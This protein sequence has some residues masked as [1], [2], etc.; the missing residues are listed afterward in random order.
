MVL[1]ASSHG[2]QDGSLRT[3]QSGVSIMLL[4]RT[5]TSFTVNSTVSETINAEDNQLETKMVWSD[6]T[7][8]E[9]RDNVT[10]IINITGIER[11][12]SSVQA[13]RI[14]QISDV[15]KDKQF[16]SNALYRKSQTMYYYS[17][18]YNFS[19]CK[20]PKVGSTFWTQVFKILKNGK[21]G[22]NVFKQERKHVHQQS[23]QLVVRFKSKRR[24][25]SKTVLVSRDP[26]S[27]LY[28]AFIDK[29]FLFMHKSTN[30]DIRKRFP[31][32][33]ASD[34]VC[35]TDVSFQEFLDF[36]ISNVKMGNL[37]N[38]H[39]A[40]ISSLCRPCDVN[41]HILVKQESFSADV[42]YALR[43]FG[44]DGE[45]L[46]MIIPALHNNRI[47]DSVIS[48][49]ETFYDKV[50][51]ACIDTY[52]VSKRLWKSFQVQGFL[53]HELSFPDKEFAHK[54]LRSQLMKDV[55]I[56]YINRYPMT[57]QERN[58]QR[59][60]ALVEAYA[61]IKEETLKGIQK[62]YEVDFKMFG[63]D[64]NPPQMRVDQKKV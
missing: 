37:L 23:T 42:E 33:N 29:S 13:E 48:I 55:V 10:K 24:K 38:R 45:K 31:K 30:Y 22:E 16:M 53:K 50:K 5:A 9:A 7:L 52:S 62:L 44:V 1:E 11:N 19:Y 63:Y 14:K 8:S 27:R 54:L 12:S 17:K 6:K 61:N 46:D 41:A 32:D 47:E 64:I 25:Q 4:E 57:S 58:Y 51:K 3:C 43:A 40:P 26:Y 49:V 34:T 28:S 15:C 59:H 35:P 21:H 2:A 60:K 56:D 36:I 39:W 20:V 18:Q